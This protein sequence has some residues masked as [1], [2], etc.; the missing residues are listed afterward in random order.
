MAWGILVPHPVIESMSSALEGEVLTPGPRGK[1]LTSFDMGQL[2]ASLCHSWHRYSSRLHASCCGGVS[3][4]GFF[5]CFLMNRFDLCALL[6]ETLHK[7]VCVLRAPRQ[8]ACD[9]SLSAVGNNIFDIWL[10]GGLWVLL[11]GYLQ[12]SMISKLWCIYTMG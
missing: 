10:S 1:S 11:A 2:L 4:F 3:Q 7:W 5:W 9:V 8:E 12:H 6:A